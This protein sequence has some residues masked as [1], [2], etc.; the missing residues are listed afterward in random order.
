MPFVNRF[1]NCS[2]DS[3]S[4]ISTRMCGCYRPFSLH[5]SCVRHTPTHLVWARLTEPKYTTL[6]ICQLV[7]HDADLLPIWVRRW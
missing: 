2:N 3:E 5:Q 4:L 6:C 1:N 7:P